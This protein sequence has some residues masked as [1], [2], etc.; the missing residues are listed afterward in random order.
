MDASA[1]HDINSITDTLDGYRDRHMEMGLK[2]VTSFVLMI[3][4]NAVK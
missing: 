4:C 2:V 3:Y 1:S